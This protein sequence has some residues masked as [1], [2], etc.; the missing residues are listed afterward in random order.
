MIAT[1]AAAALALDP[2]PDPGATGGVAAHVRRLRARMTRDVAVML[3]VPAAR[4]V[5]TDDPA[6]R[7]GGHAGH[8][9][10]VHDPDDPSTVY[11]FVPE[12]GLG[13]LY[14][15]LD[16]CRDCTAPAVPMATVAGLADLGHH[17]AATRPVPPGAPD[18]DDEENGRPDLPDEF[19][20]GPGH[21]P[22]CDFGPTGATGVGSAGPAARPDAQVLRAVAAYLAA[23]PTLEVF[24]A[25]RIAHDPRRPLRVVAEVLEMLGAAGQAELDST[26]SARRATTWSP[27][28][29]NGRPS[30]AG[31]CG[32]DA[33]GAGT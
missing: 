1:A 24:T 26:R 23:S 11:R 9:I 12:T 7:Y 32:T 15:L 20:G 25:D 27:Q 28:V 8:L 18:P 3:G 31:S 4:V 22:H 5:V 10:T 30:R 21:R 19:F 6:R 17:L 33:K 29:A 2:H 16:E 14:L 13:G